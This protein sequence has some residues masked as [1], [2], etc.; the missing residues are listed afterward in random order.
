MAG[1]IHPSIRE[2]VYRPPSPSLREVGTE[3]LEG[4]DLTVGDK[5][6]VAMDHHL[7]TMT[8][9]SRRH[10][11]I[12]IRDTRLSN[13]AT[14]GMTNTKI[15]FGPRLKVTMAAG[16]GKTSIIRSRDNMGVHLLHKDRASTAMEAEERGV[17]K[18]PTSKAIPRQIA[19][20]DLS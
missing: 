15:R 16:T 6:E 8:G 10:H 12:D 14:G 17:A 7:V 11:R 2:R 19:T 20:R 5:V 3:R 1:I 18:I 13:R 4:V 9:P